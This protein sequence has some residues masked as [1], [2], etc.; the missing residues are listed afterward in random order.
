MPVAVLNIGLVSATV[1]LG[2]HYVSDLVG[3]GVLL[4]GSAAIYQRWCADRAC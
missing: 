1:F 4:A 2:L 3:T